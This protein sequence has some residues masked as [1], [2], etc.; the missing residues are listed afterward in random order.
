[1]CPLLKEQTGMTGNTSRAVGIWILKQVSSSRR[2][3]TEP[4]RM[5]GI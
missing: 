3:L 5:Q 1:M 4:D 2:H